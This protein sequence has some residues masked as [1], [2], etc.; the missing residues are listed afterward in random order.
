[1]FVFI[2]AEQKERAFNLGLAALLGDGIY[3]FGELV[4]MSKIDSLLYDV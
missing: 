1:M 4:C 3:N 2:V